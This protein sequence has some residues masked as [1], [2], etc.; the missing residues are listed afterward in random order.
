MNS[1]KNIILP[2]ASNNHCTIIYKLHIDSFKKSFNLHKIFYL[3]YDGIYSEKYTMIEKTVIYKNTL[4]NSSFMIY[5]LNFAT[6]LKK[7]E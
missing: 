1:V 6:L 3:E 4:N 7:V 2:P 5:K